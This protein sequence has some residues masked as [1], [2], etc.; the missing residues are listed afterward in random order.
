[1]A[2]TTT[3]ASPSSSS[4]APASASASSASTPVAR[5][6][7]TKTGFD[8]LRPFRYLKAIVSGTADAT[9]NGMAN[10]GRKGM[11]LGTGI[12]VLAMLASATLYG[13]GVV[14]IGWVTGLVAGAIAGGAVGLATGGIRA[15]GRERR[16]DQ[17]SEDLMASARAKS[18][19]SSGVDYRQAH[20]E[21]QQRDNYN[22]DRFS[23]QQRE[24]HEETSTYFQ[25]QVN[26]SRHFHHER[27][28]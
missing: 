15:V 14:V 26:E 8:P 25:D 1:M 3:S 24:L 9:L 16:K 6:P 18:H 17:Y 22:Y 10:W 4:P 19:P 7:V 28:L 13:P 20:R 21:H 27:G 12:G 11:W 2:Q 23:Q 5:T